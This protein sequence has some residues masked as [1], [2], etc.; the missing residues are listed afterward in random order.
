MNTHVGQ[1]SGYCHALMSIDVEMNQ[2]DS[3]ET[4]D[5]SH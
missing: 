1:F 5:L 4:L 2:L 3:E